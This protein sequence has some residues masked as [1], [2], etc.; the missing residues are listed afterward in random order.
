MMS[1]ANLFRTFAGN[2]TQ[3]LWSIIHC[4]KLLP[5]IEIGH[6]F[7]D[8]HMCG[9]TAAIQEFLTIKGKRKVPK[10]HLNS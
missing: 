6:I 1:I 3:R 10:E 2:I 7:A 5:F 4:F 8:L 9:T